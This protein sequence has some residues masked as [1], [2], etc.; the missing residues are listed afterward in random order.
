MSGRYRAGMLSYR[1]LRKLIQDAV[2]Q[3]GLRAR[4]HELGRK[5]VTIAVREDWLD[6]DDD[7]TEVP[8]L[9]I[10]YKD[11]YSEG[12][13]LFISDELERK[14]DGTRSPVFRRVAKV[15]LDLLVPK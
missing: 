2:R 7:P 15:L 14:L 8:I 13:V 12:D 4:F 6:D 9:T 11:H 3:D 5:T 10:P 1:D